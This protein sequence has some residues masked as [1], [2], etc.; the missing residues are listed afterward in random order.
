[1]VAFLTMTGA[2]WL[3]DVELVVIVMVSDVRLS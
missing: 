2:V 3:R 1:M